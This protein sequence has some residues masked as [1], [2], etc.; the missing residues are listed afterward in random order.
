M[1]PRGSRGDA[2]AAPAPSTFS[3]SQSRMQGWGRPEL[4]GD[5]TWGWGAGKEKE[6]TAHPPPHPAL[7]PALPQQR[8]LSRKGD[9]EERGRERE[10]GRDQ[11]R[12]TGGRCRVTEEPP[13]AAHLEPLPA[14][15]CVCRRSAPPAGTSIFGHSRS[16][17]A[18][19]VLVSK[20]SLRGGPPIIPSA[21]K[22]AQAC[23]RSQGRGGL[24]VAATWLLPRHLLSPRAPPRMLTEARPRETRSGPAPTR[25][26]PPGVL[27]KGLVMRR[28]LGARLEEAAAVSPT[29]A[30][31]AHTASGTRGQASRRRGRGVGPCTIWGRTPARADAPPS[32]AGPP[33]AVAAEG[34]QR[35]WRSCSPSL[36]LISLDSSSFP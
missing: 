24:G 32:P 36:S 12:R 10:G 11:R 27:R 4:G 28:R 15:G 18:D 22:E 2:A 29:G 21:D 23:L 16:F 14:R 6:D 13:R 1:R 8:R 25:A 35:G 34:S 9:L 30:S 19:Y 7:P 3:R 5:R 26:S 31:L 17:C 33:G 20:A